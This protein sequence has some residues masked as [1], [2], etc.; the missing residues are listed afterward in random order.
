MSLEIQTHKQQYTSI[1][2]S[3]D[4]M[5]NAIYRIG[6]HTKVPAPY[7]HWMEVSNLYAA[8]T[9]L[10]IAIAYYGSADGNPMYN[11]LILSVRRTGG[12]HGV[13]KVVHILW[14]NGNHY[15]QLLMNDDS[16]PLPPVHVNWRAATDSACRDLER[17]YH[18]RISHWNRLCGVQSQQ[19]KNTAE[20]AVNLDTP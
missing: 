15:V 11:C 19:R 18:N 1:Y 4:A 9:F 13:N 16:S 3:A 12:T 17:Q 20:D 6:G 10:N 8:A 7:L 5:E 14:V 2:L